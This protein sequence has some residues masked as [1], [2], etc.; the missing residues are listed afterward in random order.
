VAPDAARTSKKGKSWV[1]KTHRDRRGQGSVKQRAGVQ[2]PCALLPA[3]ADRDFV[4]HFA[5][6]RAV[7]RA[8]R[9]HG[10]CVRQGRQALGATTAVHI[11]SSS[12]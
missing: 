5:T 11:S 10:L 1:K 4:A 6:F 12:W 2:R 9:F 3:A 8:S 7:G